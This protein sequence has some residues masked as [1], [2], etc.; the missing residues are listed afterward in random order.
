MTA[1]NQET[2]PQ[3]GRNQETPLQAGRPRL[4]FTRI[5]AL[6]VLFWALPLMGLFFARYID[7]VLVVFLAILFSTF[8]TP[9]ANGLER[10]HI[11]R[12]I[13][14]LLVY[15]AILGVLYLVVSLA[16]PL[17]I[18]E[19]QALV[20]EIPAYL[21]RF[22]GP[23]HAIGL[24]LPRGGSLNI[25]NMLGGF[26]ANGN[27][28]V[29]GIAGTAIGV[30]LSTATLAVE[31]LAML[32]MAFFLTVQKTFTRDLVNTLVPPAH[33]MRWITHMSRA[34]ERMGGWVVGQI[35][36]TVYYAVVFSAG[37][38][39]IHLPNELSIG[40]ITGLLEII[41]FV[42]GFIGLLLAVLVALTVNPSLIIWV[43]IL[44]LIV[45]NVEAHILVP[46]IYGRTVHIHPFLVI[47]ALLFGAEAF[48]IIGAI[49]AVPIAAALQVAVMGIYVR[50]VVTPAEEGGQTRP[51][52]KRPLVDLTR[53]PGTERLRRRPH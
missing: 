25:R 34:G 49:I 36:I 44:Y 11:N 45:T 48:G 8:L 21:N 41:P 31:I 15:L 42:G 20:N 35:I 3:A 37:L 47:V 13:A 18:N 27:H 22:S 17:F 33:R 10:L 40:L 50:D 1:Y 28:S 5:A 43:V 53:L 30:V 38:A 32:V 19:T 46:L 12:G 23:L 2:P 16:V 52:L 9:V 39:L 24:N 4:S 51:R 6:I 26:L 7:I 14:I 29:G